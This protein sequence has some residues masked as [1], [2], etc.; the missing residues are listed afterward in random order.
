MSNYTFFAGAP[1]SS[2][3]CSKLLIRL[4]GFFLIVSFFFRV[5]QLGGIFLWSPSLIGVRPTIRRV[6]DNDHEGNAY[7]L[8]M[9]RTCCSLPIKL[10]QTAVHWPKKHI[11]WTFNF[12][13]L[14]CMRLV[15]R[16]L[17]WNRSQVTPNCELNGLLRNCGFKVKVPLPPVY[18]LFYRQTTN[19]CEWPSIHPPAKC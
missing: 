15:V 18:S 7:L 8:Y 3:V 10:M 11:R 17:D 14:F 6:H 13:V 16:S 4:W 5:Q 19:V 9:C 2:S 12:R 1:V